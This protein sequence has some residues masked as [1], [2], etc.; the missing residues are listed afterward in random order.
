MC[1]PGAERQVA[2][3]PPHSFFPYKEQLLGH[4]LWAVTTAALCA[5]VEWNCSFLWFLAEGVTSLSVLVKPR[6]LPALLWAMPDASLSQSAAP[7]A[8]RHF[9][10]SE[11]WPRGNWRLPSPCTA[12]T[13][14][15]PVLTSAHAQWIAEQWL[16]LISKCDCSSSSWPP[17]PLPLLLM[18][19]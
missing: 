14:E 8:P 19:P 18:N 3:P 12:L 2:F 4:G 13:V 16:I 7:G 1:V 15:I 5:G 9:W 6:G 10:M 11:R 17:V